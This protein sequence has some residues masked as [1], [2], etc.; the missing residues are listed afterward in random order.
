M[1]VSRNWFRAFLF[2]DNS[3]KIPQILYQIIEN[4]FLNLCI[5]LF[6]MKIS[7]SF[8]WIFVPMYLIFFVFRLVSF[9]V[10]VMVHYRLSY[11]CGGEVDNVLLMLKLNFEDSGTMEFLFHTSFS[12]KVISDCL[13]STL[14]HDVL[15][16]LRWWGPLLKPWP[17]ICVG[18]RSV[19]H[20]SPFL[21][22]CSSMDS[23]LFGGF[24]RS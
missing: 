1:V 18:L 14:A 8:T 9:L 6:G 20:C 24:P 19:P 16:C 10:L 13:P 22:P 4:L 2:C 15:R 5:A 3:I 17:A 11:R 21:I 23:S 12:C 7:G